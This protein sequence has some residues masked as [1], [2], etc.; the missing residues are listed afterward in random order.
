MFVA[1]IWLAFLPYSILLVWRGLFHLAK[2]WGT[3]WTAAIQEIEW[4]TVGLSGLFTPHEDH[5][6]DSSNATITS[7]MAAQAAA[8]IT[9]AAIASQT[10]VL[11]T[12]D[13]DGG[14]IMT[15]SRMINGTIVST[16]VKPKIE[17]LEDAIAD[18]FKAWF[19]PE[20][21]AGAVQRTVVDKAALLASNATTTSSSWLP[22]SSII[23][24]AFY[25]STQ[26]LS[27]KWKANKD[28]L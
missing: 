20:G 26:A 16:S 5:L 22:R 18:L 6:R 13:G 14:A 1:F 23:D 28:F 7:A 21:T 12:Q 15:L 4:S 8:G 2:G 27:S 17:A 24:R 19:K 10:T 3:S 11:G 9:P 25:A